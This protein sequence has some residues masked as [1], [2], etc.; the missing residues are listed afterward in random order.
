MLS[1]LMDVLKSKDVPYLFLSQNEKHSTFQR[2]LILKSF[3][4]VN[5]L[6]NRSYAMLETGLVSKFY[7]LTLRKNPEVRTS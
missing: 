7:Q 5:P 2:T 4:I 6:G 1:R 3:Q